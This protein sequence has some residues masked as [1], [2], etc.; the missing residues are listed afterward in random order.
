MYRYIRNVS[1]RHQ[2]RV[3][4]HAG[5]DLEVLQF[6]GLHL[7]VLL[8]LGHPVVQL[9]T[10]VLQ[11]THTAFNKHELTRERERE[12][13]KERGRERERERERRNEGERGREGG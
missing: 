13:E 10:Q 9:G 1:V 8:M 3:Q 12:R 4:V 2:P 6:S 5:T 11:N 7:C